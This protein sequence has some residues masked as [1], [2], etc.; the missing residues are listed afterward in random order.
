MNGAPEISTENAIFRKHVTVHGV[1]MA[2]VDVGEGDPI[3][4]LHGNPTPS[5]LWRN[6]IPHALPFGRCLAPDY[7]GMGNS[8]AEPNGAY[9][10]VDQQNYVDG[11]LDALG[12]DHDVI[13]VVHDWG[14]ALGFDWARRHPDKVQAIVHMEGIVRP[15]LSWDE[16]PALTRDFFRGQR[17][18]AGEKMILEQNLFIEYL[19]P[20]RGLSGE[21]MEAYRSHFRVPGEAR[22]PM[23]AWTRDLPIA[24]E[25]ADVVAIVE[26]Y[27]AWLMSSQIPK[28][29]IN[30]DPAGFLIGAQRDYCRGFPNQQEV[31]VEG[32]HFLQE[33]SPRE[34]GEAI[35]KFIAAVLAGRFAAA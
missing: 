35:A 12:L 24:G 34:V 21:A 13:L 17:T 6:I 30:G 9:R 20:L 18:P 10:L 27:S 25:P 7:P 33:D 14:S 16:W 11:W 23:L 28:L 22:R 4:F 2:Y 1:P 31:T 19:L 29:F 8:G 5:Y 15:F 26:A 3:V 32:A